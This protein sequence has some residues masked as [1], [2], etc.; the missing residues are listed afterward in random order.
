MGNYFDLEKLNKHIE[1]LKNRPKNIGCVTFFGGISV[2][3]WKKLKSSQSGT[4][5]TK[6]IN[7]G[8]KYLKY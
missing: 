4:I 2:I 6:P 5:D 3:T 7:D 1:Y 8:T